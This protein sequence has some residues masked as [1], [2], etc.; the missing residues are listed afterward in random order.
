ML[1]WVHHVQNNSAEFGGALDVVDSNV[2]W[3]GEAYSCFEENKARFGDALVLDSAQLTCTEKTIT[4]S[5]GSLATKRGGAIDMSGSSAVFG[6]DVWFDTSSA[7]E[8]LDIFESGFGGALVVARGTNVA[9][10]RDLNFT[11][12]SAENKAKDAGGPIYVSGTGFS[13]ACTGISFIFNSAQV[14]GAASFV[15]S[16]NLKQERKSPNPTIFDRW[17]FIGNRATATGESAAG[18]DFT[19]DSVFE[20][21]RTGAG[22]G[23][24]TD[25]CFGRWRGGSRVEYRSISTMAHISLSGNAFYCQQGMFL[26]FQV[27]FPSCVR[28]ASYTFASSAQ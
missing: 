6:G 18:Q 22:R 3:P 13:P 7:T 28:H 1:E 5:T 25:R 10:H 14:G 9:W 16:G 20:G 21:N 19:A 26:V 17:I 4:A 23:S 2:C 12:N 8:E 27:S 15:A 24:A 11:G